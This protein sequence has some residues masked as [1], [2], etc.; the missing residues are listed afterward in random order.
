MMPPGMCEEAA[1]VTARAALLCRLLLLARA[2]RASI[3]RIA[4]ALTLCP[5]SFGCA[6]VP[7]E[8]VQ[9]SYQIGQDLPRLHESF[10]GLIRDRFE[11]FRAQRNAYVDDVWAPTFLARW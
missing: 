8:A 4:V 6:H 10:D 11:D 9:L 1:V 5:L 3:P 2:Y 7:K